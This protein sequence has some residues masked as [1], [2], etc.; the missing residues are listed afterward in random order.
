MPEVRDEHGAGAVSRAVAARSA[1][2]RASACTPTGGVLI[3]N[4]GAVAGP[5]NSRLLGT[6][7]CYAK[8]KCPD[9]CGMT[10]ER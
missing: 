1:E 6:V 4:V 2:R 8:D 3:T 9:A 5:G 10:I 7:P